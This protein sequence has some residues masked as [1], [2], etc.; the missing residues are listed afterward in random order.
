MTL[1]NRI[2]GPIY[3]V[4][5]CYKRNHYDYMIV[6]AVTGTLTEAQRSFHSISLLAL[7]SFVEDGNECKLDFAETNVFCGG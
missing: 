5:F 6:V 1:Y 2:T 4:L 7:S 3:Y